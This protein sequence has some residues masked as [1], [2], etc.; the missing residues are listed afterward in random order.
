MNRTDHMVP[1]MDYAVDIG[2]LA[3]HRN[4][5]EGT[6][7]ETIATMTSVSLDV[8]STAMSGSLSAAASSAL[9]GRF[10][11]AGGELG[12]SLLKYVTATGSAVDGYRQQED[13]AAQAINSFFGS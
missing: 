5:V 4:N 6:S 2:V 9:Q 8:A 3:S 7:S 13:E 10:E 11:S 1:T 12:N